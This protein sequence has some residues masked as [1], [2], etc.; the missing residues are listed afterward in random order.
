M[1]VE[2]DGDEVYVNLHPKQVK[3]LI[4]ALEAYV[5]EVGKSKGEREVLSMKIM[6]NEGDRSSTLSA[7]CQKD[8][9]LE[10][11]AMPLMMLVEKMLDVMNVNPKATLLDVGMVVKKKGVIHD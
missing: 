4:S 9:P 2:H 5:N 7:V 10:S 8:A 1:Q 11:V 3:T 6:H